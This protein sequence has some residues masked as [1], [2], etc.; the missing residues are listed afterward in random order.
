MTGFTSGRNALLA[1]GAVLAGVFAGALPVA[2]ATSDPLSVNLINLL[3]KQHVIT[4]TAAKQLLAEAQR[5]TAGTQAAPASP[6]PAAAA[7]TPPPAPGAARISYVPQL[8]RDQISDEVQQK[9]IA[10]AKTENW[11]QPNQIAPWTKR[12][13]ISGDV[14]FRDEWD[15]YSRNNDPE[16]INFAALNANGP[17]DVNPAT[18][19]AGI[20]FTN[21]TK[22]RYNQLAVRARLDVSAIV[23]PSVS[24]DIRLGT[25]QS[26]SP[27]STTQLLGGGLTKKDIWLDRAYIHLQPA[28]WI[29]GSLGRMPNPFFSTDMVYDTDLNFDGAATSGTWSPF[30]N[31]SLTLTEG[32]FLT[33]SLNPNFPNNSDIKSPNE[34]K[35]MFG[36]QLVATW[37][38]DRY[39][40]KVGAAYYSFQNQ[41]GQLSEPC[42]LYTGITECSTDWSQPAFMQKGNTLFLVRNITPDPTNSL[43]GAQPLPQLAGLVFPYHIL[44]L[45]SQFDITLQDGKHVTFTGDYAR[46]LAYNHSA[47]CRYGESGLPITNVI[48]APES[49]DTDVCA[50]ATANGPQFK[51]GPNA[52][53]V[54]GFYG[55][56]DPYKWGEWSFTAGYKYIAADAL[57]DAYTDADFHLGGTNAKGYYLIST[58]GLLDGLN[59]QAR[60]F[61]A[62]EVSGPPLSIDVGQLDFN[63][64][65]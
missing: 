34:M 19:P 16:L 20:P 27:V 38:Q 40:W 62:D 52:F 13:T 57:I 59:V 3:V 18:N 56:T 17:I 51:S 54:Q 14:R 48:S 23:S 65:F 47:V 15:L 5:E 53:M 29:Q 25:G 50:T 43:P 42:A 37:T 31:L 49:T 2:A 21:D 26:N 41:Q 61:S 39:S 64:R 11:A 30:R 36:S 8:V 55:D 12:I 10:Q 46:N 58:L 6:V 4:P 22:N 1:G 7:V 45:T 63:V 32:A 60:W 33:D 24:A 9:V 28:S 35:W 44:N